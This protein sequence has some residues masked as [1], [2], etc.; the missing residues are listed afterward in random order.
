MVNKVFFVWG[1]KH[2]FSIERSKIWRKNNFRELR[3]SGSAR[4]NGTTIKSRKKHISGGLILPKVS[5]RVSGLG[6]RMGVTDRYLIGSG[7]L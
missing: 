1:E 6:P 2:K 5:L 7:S 3:A 4:H